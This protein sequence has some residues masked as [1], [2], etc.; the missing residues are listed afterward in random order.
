MTRI[1]CQI[2]GAVVFFGLLFTVNAHAAIDSN[3]VL[4]NV[5]NQYWQVASQWSSTLTAA[6]TRLFWSLVIISMVWTFGM[7]LLRKADIGEF[8]AEFIRF[9]IF[10]GFFWWLLT[11]GPV[12]ANS[13]IESLT[14]LG[15][16]AS[17]LGN[18][19]LPSSIVD[20]GFG[21][22]SK[23][24]DG[25][26]I[27]EPIDSAIGIIIALIILFILALIG[28]NMLLLMVAAWILA[29]AGIFFLGFGGSRWT[30]D[31]AVN[32]YKTV[33]GLAGQI[34]TVI[35]LV[36][37]GKTFIDNYYVNMDAGITLKDMAVMLIVSLV[38]LELVN[39]VPHL[40]GG[41]ANGSS[42]HGPGIGSHGAAAG[43]GMMGLAA[44][45]AMTGGSA[46]KAGL[47]SAGGGASAVMAAVSKGSQ[48]VAATTDIL[49][50]FGGQSPPSS[51]STGSN[52]GNGTPLAEAAGFSGS[53]SVSSASQSGQ[54]K[55]GGP[56]SSA[57]IAGRVAVDAVANLARGTKE[58]GK[59]KFDELKG[60]AIQAM[61]E[62]TGGK[63]AAAIRKSR[64][65]DL[66]SPENNNDSEISA[67]R[68]GSD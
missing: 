41:I 39:K 9:T 55:G 15:S 51:G 10:T 2:I 63:I 36:G 56:I 57:G 26:K 45:A 50:G 52:S 46:I 24:I 23:V 43:L 25:S 1:L 4:D 37:I 3:G 30:S 13:I 8:F 6:A 14:Q 49:S 29:Y 21:I 17:G 59:N 66:K 7:M 38:L 54:N 12:F 64:S 5:L 65:E 11:N 40:I 62:T 60:S 34:M 32:Y 33:L 18:S 28:I 20:V 16:T 48:N 58:V 27:L 61:S 31:M 53:S 44:A 35:L 67:F 42:L 47:T 19:F 68:D 22:F